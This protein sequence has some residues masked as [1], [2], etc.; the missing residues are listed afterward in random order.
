MARTKQWADDS[1]TQIKFA[2]GGSLT[3]TF[4]GNLFDLLV[5]ERQL[6][7]ELSGVI[8]GYNL[9]APEAAVEVKQA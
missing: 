3:L 4:H 9:A 5:H 2:R 8:Q 7:T 1:S 6:I